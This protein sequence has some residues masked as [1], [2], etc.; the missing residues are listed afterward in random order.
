MSSSC[1]SVISLLPSYLLR[2]FF[3]TDVF[4]FCFS[5]CFH[6]ERRIL[7]APALSIFFAGSLQN[8]A[9]R[10]N[11][12]RFHRNL[13]SALFQR[14]FHRTLHSRTARNFHTCNRDA[15]NLI[16]QE[17]PRKLLGIV[18]VVEF[19]TTHQHNMIADE[20]L[21]EVSVRIRRTV[22]RNEKVRS[23]TSLICTGHWRSCDGAAAPF[24]AAFRPLSVFCKSAASFA[25]RWFSF[26][27]S[28]SYG[29]ASRSTNEIAS[30]GQ[31]GR[32]SPKPSQ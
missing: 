31:T 32:Q 17:N 18:D 3:G 2:I 12:N 13:L 21:M 27:A 9:F 19:C 22:R 7:S 14:H 20:I 29:S 5:R 24:S 26:T 1:I 25:F 15:L 4:L 6:G 10:R 28:S 23:C 8:L 11:H 30:A 16:P